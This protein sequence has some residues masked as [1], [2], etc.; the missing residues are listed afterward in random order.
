MADA[1]PLTTEECA[2]ALG[3]AIKTVRKQVERGK[4]T[5]GRFGRQLTFDVAEVER[6]RRENLGRKGNPA[7]RRSE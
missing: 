6:Y 1:T 3:I 5:A 4:L 7:W 2:A